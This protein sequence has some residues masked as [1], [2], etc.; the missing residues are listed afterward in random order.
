MRY[1]VR[2]EIGLEAGGGKVWYRGSRMM[3]AKGSKMQ[4]TARIK[5]VE[6]QD[7]RSRKPYCQNGFHVFPRGRLC[8]SAP[9]PGPA[10]PPPLALTAPYSA[11][12]RGMQWEGGHLSRDQKAL[13]KLSF[14]EAQW[15]RTA[16]PIV[17]R[18]GEVCRIGG[19]IGLWPHPV[20][21]HMARAG[22]FYLLKTRRSQSCIR[23][24]IAH[25]HDS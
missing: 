24:W 2:V 3:D 4:S 7:A 21:S 10:H 17:A 9:A 13:W 6:E 20:S 8:A 25:W 1:S 23:I 15:A 19:R 18:A 14:T 22:V 12:P 16:E 5:D 11:H